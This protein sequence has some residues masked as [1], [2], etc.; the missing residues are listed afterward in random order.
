MGKI[1][2]A[3]FIC[4]LILFILCICISL[5]ATI[6][7]DHNKYYDTS[8]ILQVINVNVDDDFVLVKIKIS[9]ITEKPFNINSYDFRLL[10]NNNEITYQSFKKPIRIKNKT[11]NS[12]DVITG[13][14]VFEV[15]KNES[16]LVLEYDPSFCSDKTIKVSLN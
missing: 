13:T 9:N 14:L 4:V 12:N 16:K 6:Y 11:V 10:N 8:E 1:F 3:T 15:P 2:N 7:T 5:V